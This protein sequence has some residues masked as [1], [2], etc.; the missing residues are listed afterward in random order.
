[1]GDVVFA[2]FY[3]VLKRRG[4][5]F[6]FFHRLEN[7]RL[8]A[9]PADGGEPPHVA[10][11][12]FD[13]QAE[14]AAAAASTSRSSTC[15][16][17]RAGRRRRDYAQLVDGERLRARR[18]GTSS[19]TGTAAR[20]AHARR[21]ASARTSTSS[22]SASAS[23]RSRTSCREI[24]ARDPRWRAMVEHVKTVATQA[25]QVWLRAGHGASSAGPRP[26]I[27]LSGFVEPFDTW[28]DMR[29]LI[30]REELAEPPRAAR[31]LLQRAARRRCAAEPPATATTRRRSASRCAATP[32]TS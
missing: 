30:A 32:S 2:P 4:V 13:V 22:C 5:R 7:V 9:E 28:A 12:E 21:C 20:V 10:A 8:A 15:A 14:V 23:A 18:A 27:T 26:P 3:E 25:F 16:G 1:M 11:L 24:V 19:R 17:C 31:L 6:E 29:H